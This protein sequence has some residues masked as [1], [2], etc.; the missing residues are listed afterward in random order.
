[1]SLYDTA[2]NGN[3]TKGTLHNEAEETQDAISVGRFTS[4]KGQWTRFQNTIIMRCYLSKGHTVTD[5][6]YTNEC[7]I[8]AV[9][10][11]IWGAWVWLPGP[12]LQHLPYM[13]SPIVQNSCV[14]KVKGK[15]IPVTGHGGRLGCET[16]GLPHF[17]D[18][19]LI[20][21]GEAV[22]LTTRPPFTTRKIPGTHFC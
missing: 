12:A 2:W 7:F 19:R 10:V 18:N 6:W 13:T 14:V 17:L 21:G 16:S 9:T 1:M 8:S 22:C 3:S 20:D 11:Y 15:A 5:M 4:S